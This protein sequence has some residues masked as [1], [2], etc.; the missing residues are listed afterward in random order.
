LDDLFTLLIFVLFIAGPIIERVLRGARG[1]Q[2]RPPQRRPVPGQRPPQR[3][4]PGTYAPPQPQ[5]QPRETTSSQPADATD[6]V[7]AELWE[8]LTGQPRP[9]APPPQPRTPPSRVLTPAQ[10]EA[11]DE[12]DET[13]EVSGAETR[14]SDEESA[15]DE[16]LKRR[17][18][19]TELARKVEHAPPVIVSLETEP[20]LPSARHVAFHKKVDP[21]PKAAAPKVKVPAVT[22]AMALLDFNDRT[23]LQRA[24]LLQ[25]V[26]GKPKALE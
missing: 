21:K 15:L 20:A 25:E 19:G 1:Q 17:E 14:G 12:E 3:T 2:Q 4:L 24:V 5:P 10:A 16:L 8:I 6:L 7:P 22:P 13:L 9:T 23:A 18:R 26:L 11:E